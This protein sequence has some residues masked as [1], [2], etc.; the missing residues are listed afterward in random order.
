[1]TGLVYSRNWPRIAQL[2]VLAILILY[3]VCIQVTAGRFEEIEDPVVRYAAAFVIVQ[4][5]VLSLLVLFVLVGKLIRMRWEFFRATRVARLTQLLADPAADGAVLD[6]SRKWPAEFLTVIEE[7]VQALKGSVRAR[8][9]GLM[10]RSAPYRRLLGE[11]LDRNPSRAI[12]AIS[13]LGQL[14]TPRARQAVQR[15]L[16]HRT[17]AVRQAARKAILQGSDQ[18]AQ[19]KLLDTA[20]QLS[21]WHRLVMFHYAPTDTPLLPE[22]VAEALQSTDEERILAALELILT[23]QR[24]VFAP[25]PVRLAR[26]TNVEIR[27]KFFKALPFLQLDGDAT[28]VLQSGLD[29]PDWRVRAMAAR[30]CAHFR[31]AV[32]ADRLLEMCR[33][34]EYPPESAHAARAL[35]VMGGEGWLRL[36]DLANSDHGLSRRIAT[37]VVERRLLGGVA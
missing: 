7:A 5:T 17:G 1:M 30:S 25:A 3:I 8:V 13:L 26:S 11:T 27:V 9:I 16:G 35:A 12:R 29:D 21:G 19:R 22:F 28:V 2:L 23:Q 31:P 32:L 6:A 14:D 20:P 10:E 36:Q 34:F 15:G 33:I 37:E 18:A 4:S 24:V